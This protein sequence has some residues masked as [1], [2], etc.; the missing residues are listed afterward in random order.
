MSHGEAVNSVEVIAIEDGLIAVVSQSLRLKPSS[1]F[2]TGDENG[3]Y[4]YAE[5]LYEGVWRIVSYTYTHHEDKTCYYDADIELDELRKSLV[6]AV[7]FSYGV[8]V[9]PE[10]FLILDKPI[11]L[12]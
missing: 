7:R 1:A 10:R 5:I 8:H 2:D 9:T 6:K 11:D 4:L 3:G 12:K